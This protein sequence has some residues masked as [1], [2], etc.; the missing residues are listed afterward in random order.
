MEVWQSGLLR[1]SRKQECALKSHREFES[2]CFLQL[3]INT[4]FFN[5]MNSLKACDIINLWKDIGWN[6]YSDWLNTIND[7]NFRKNNEEKLRILE[8]YLNPEHINAVEFWKACEKHFSTDAVCSARN[9]KGITLSKK[10]GNKNNWLLFENTG[11]M[12]LMNIA[13]TSI[14]NNPGLRTKTIVEVGS[15]YGCFIKNYKNKIKDFEYIPF[16]IIKRFQGV[17]LLKK[18]D[19]GFFTEQQ[20]S[21]MKNGIGCVLCFNVLQHLSKDQTNFYLTQFHEI[22]NIGGYLLVSYV[23][24]HSSRSTMYGQTI[25]L[26]SKEEFRRNLE[27]KNFK[28]LAEN[29]FNMSGFDPC[30]FLCQK[31]ILK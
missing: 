17:R 23:D 11:A 25:H 14:R 3:I 24:S 5:K 18:S 13:I 30:V 29:Y 20:I 9:N 19:Q 1:L 21:A 22:L 27:K 4:I 2:H 6:S 31:K 26:F 16:D 10:Q 7:Y 28:I 12:A 8:Y 15:G